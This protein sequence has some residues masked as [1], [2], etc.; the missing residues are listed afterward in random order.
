MFTLQPVH[1]YAIIN[2]D[3]WRVTVLQDNT[4]ID[5]SPIQRGIRFWLVINGEKAKLVYIYVAP[6]FRHEWL[7]SKIFQRLKE[8]A[9]ECGCTT[10]ELD[11][12]YPVRNFWIKNWVEVGE[13]ITL[14]WTLQDYVPCSFSL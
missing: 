9:K 5:S 6:R 12:Y 10:M 11:A 3:E 8:Y 1:G 13:R 7:G 4:H 14:N 2:A